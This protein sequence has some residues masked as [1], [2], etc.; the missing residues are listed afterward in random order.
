M[1]LVKWA[2]WARSV[3][4]VGG[5]LYTSKNDLHTT[6][7]SFTT[8]PFLGFF[9]LRGGKIRNPKCVRWVQIILDSFKISLLFYGLKPRKS[10]YSKIREIVCNHI[11][12]TNY[13]YKIWTK[14]VSGQSKPIPPVPECYQF[15]LPALPIFYIMNQGFWFHSLSCRNTL[16]FFPYRT[17]T[18]I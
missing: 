10:Y 15:N 4:S 3:F 18:R 12:H 5:D 7:I 16:E 14:S 8:L 13:V 11:W 9:L 17:A 6:N 1:K 2:E